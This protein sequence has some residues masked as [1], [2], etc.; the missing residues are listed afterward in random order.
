[1]EGFKEGSKEKKKFPHSAEGAS[2]SLLS[3]LKIPQP[4]S[5]SLPVF[6]SLCYVLC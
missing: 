2:S 5:L 4:G 3:L 1:M 6:F